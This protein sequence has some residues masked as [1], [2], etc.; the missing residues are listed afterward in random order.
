[1]ITDDW[2]A[3]NRTENKPES[4]IAEE[5]TQT[6]LFQTL[7]H[8]YLAGFWDQSMQ[9]LPPND[10]LLEVGTTVELLRENPSYW[11]TPDNELADLASDMSREAEQL[12]L[13]ISAGRLADR[14]SGIVED[15]RLA[16]REEADRKGE[17]RAE[18]M[19]TELRMARKEERK[20]RVV[21]GLDGAEDDRVD[22]GDEEVLG[23]VKGRHLTSREFWG[24]IDE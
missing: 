12:E 9:P 3:L 8:G 13:C 6:L 24:V 23:S 18:V 2:P 19:E 22:A 10:A 16:V 14:W 21:S 5:I 7:Y 17:H 20:D 4:V 1:M 15:A 11:N